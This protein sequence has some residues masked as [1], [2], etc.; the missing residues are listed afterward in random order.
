MM[1][2]MVMVSAQ[3]PNDLPTQHK[4]TMT[5]AI[6][7]N[8]NNSQ[9]KATMANQWIQMEAMVSRQGSSLLLHFSFS[10]S[11]GLSF[12]FNFNFSFSF[13]FIYSLS[14][15]SVLWKKWSKSFSSFFLFFENF[16]FR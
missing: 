4:G 11:F 1:R 7:P 9:P 2:L 15:F 13:S 6:I 3:Q 16:N 14:S 5:V 8:C 12:I 10:F